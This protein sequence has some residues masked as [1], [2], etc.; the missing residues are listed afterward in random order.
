[1]YSLSFDPVSTF[2]HDRVE[3]AG[4][5]RLLFRVWLV[6]ACIYLTTPM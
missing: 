1:V 6:P 4:S 2:V 3:I 5:V